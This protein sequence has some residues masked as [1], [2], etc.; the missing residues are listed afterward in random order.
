MNIEQAKKDLL[1][2]LESIDKEKLSLPD[3]RLYAD[4]LKVISE[5]QT[6]TYAEAL[7]E[8]MSSMTMGIGTY[9]APTVSEMK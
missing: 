6:K 8:T 9:K 2:T 5:I 7:S 1:K 4:T 3:L